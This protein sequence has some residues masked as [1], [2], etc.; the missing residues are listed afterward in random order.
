MTGI[1]IVALQ[2]KPL[3]R[4]SHA[5]GVISGRRGDYAARALGGGKLR[6]LVVGAAQLEGEN[7]LLVFALE[8]YAVADAARQRRRE[9]E[10]RLDRDVVHLRGQDLLQIV[11]RH[12]CLTPDRSTGERSRKVRAAK[13]ERAPHCPCFLLG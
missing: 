11:N 12:R 13:A 2:P 4:K 5:L 1:T 3:R 7:G 10:R 8:Q 6:H 9:V